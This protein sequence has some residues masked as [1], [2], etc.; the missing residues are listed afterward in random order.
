VAVAG[1]EASRQLVVEMWVYVPD[2]KL[3][4]LLNTKRSTVAD[5]IR[6]KMKKNTAEQY[7]SAEEGPS[8]VKEIARDA[9]ETAIG[10]DAAEDIL[11]KSM[12]VR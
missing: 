2:P 4:A 10:K 1:T 6:D 3:K 9:V 5:E 11:I 8:L 7:L 12:I